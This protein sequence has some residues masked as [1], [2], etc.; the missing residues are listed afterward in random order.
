MPRAQVCD[1]T[2]WSSSLKYGLWAS[3]PEAAWTA[4]SGQ[5]TAKLGAGSGVTVW[6]GGS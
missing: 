6:H 3:K 5:W 4:D 1:I 2:P